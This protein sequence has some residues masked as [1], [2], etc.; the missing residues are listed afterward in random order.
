MLFG[1]V[2]GAGVGAFVHTPQTVYELPNPRSAPPP[3]P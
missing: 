3:K 1:T 2:L